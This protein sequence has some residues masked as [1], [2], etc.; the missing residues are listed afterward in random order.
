M[1]TSILRD[2]ALW[3]IAAHRGESGPLRNASKLMASDPKGVRTRNNAIVLALLTR[4]NEVAMRELAESLFTETPA[5]A[6]VASI[7]ALALYLSGRDRDALAVMARFEAESLSEPRSALYYAIFLTVAKQPDQAKEYLDFAG[8]GVL[9][10]EE[11]ALVTRA[12]LAAKEGSPPPPAV[13]PD[14]LK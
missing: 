2:D 12:K 9:P 4:S 3:E 14:A 6:A 7:H 5:D 13:T 11:K 8:I 1:R 10:V